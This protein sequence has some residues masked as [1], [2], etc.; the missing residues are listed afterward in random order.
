[1]RNRQISGRMLRNWK[2]TQTKIDEQNYYNGELFVYKIQEG[3]DAGLSQ[4]SF[5]QFYTYLKSLQ[6]GIEHY[7]VLEKDTSP[8]LIDTNK[9]QVKWE[10]TKTQQVGDS[11]TGGWLTKVIQSQSI[12][13]VVLGDYKINNKIKLFSLEQPANEVDSTTKFYVAKETRPHID[14]AGN[15]IGV[16]I[17]AISATE[18]LNDE[19]IK[20]NWRWSLI[21][22][23]P[24]GVKKIEIEFSKAVLFNSIELGGSPKGQPISSNIDLITQN[25]ISNISWTYKTNSGIRLRPYLL[26]AY[27]A[28]NFATI[29][30]SEWPFE[31]DWFNNAGTKGWTGR[32]LM[33]FRIQEVDNK[34][35]FKSVY[36]DA[37]SS[38]NRI[39]ELYGGRSNNGYSIMNILPFYEKTPET[40]SPEVVRITNSNM[41][42]DNFDYKSF[43]NGKVIN[44]KTAIGNDGFEQIETQFDQ[45][46]YAQISKRYNSSHSYV[47]EIIADNG[48]EK[49]D[50]SKIGKNGIA[51]LDN[52]G[53]VHQRLGQPDR[54]FIMAGNPNYNGASLETIGNEFT[55]NFFTR[56]FTYLGTTIEKF[57]DK[58]SPLQ[59]PKLADYTSNDRKYFTICFLP[60]VDN[61]YEKSFS[62]IYETDLV[63]GGEKRKELNTIT[64][65]NKSLYSANFWSIPSYSPTADTNLIPDQTAD[66]NNEYFMQTNDRRLTLVIEL[67][68]EYDMNQ[69]IV[70]S[71]AKYGADV[72]FRFYDAQNNIVETN[73]RPV[74]STVISTSSTTGSNFII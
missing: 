6:T 2:E 48:S 59:K 13:F 5:Q 32:G 1:M 50:A 23:R 29:W 40:I 68:N 44:F 3:Q 36:S 62:F 10:R 66:I 45:L 56:A 73:R 53:V 11:A 14:R 19:N 35:T 27:P 46:N 72:E 38:N 41:R 55:K 7:I 15:V 71:F 61:G 57:P 39:N 8:E 17:D 26:P 31:W 58:F 25:R 43:T 9:L 4:G 64:T 30:K 20:A 33:N 18:L 69:W 67:D 37:F 47:N 34:E 63:G 22:K 24:L 60:F 12:S 28:D 54:V 16:E 70:R 65:E 51:H 49:M 21:P 52:L 74:A 42:D